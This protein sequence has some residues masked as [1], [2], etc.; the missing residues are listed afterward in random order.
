LN[1]GGTNLASYIATVSAK[2]RQERRFRQLEC[3]TCTDF[4]FPRAE[5]TEFDDEAIAK[6]EQVGYLR[7]KPQDGALWAYMQQPFI[8]TLYRM[9][10]QRRN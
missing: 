4:A 6:L 7:L 9:M 8:D 1:P 10:E 3:L 2:E 5:M